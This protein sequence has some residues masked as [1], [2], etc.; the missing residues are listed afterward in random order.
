M[1]SPRKSFGASGSFVGLSGL[2]TSGP[3][4]VH[5]TIV[6]HAAE[7]ISFNIVRAGDILEFEIKFLNV[8]FP[9][10]DFWGSVLVEERKVPM[11]GAD[12]KGDIVKEIIQLVE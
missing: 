11:I 4:S 6:I 3:W 10:D 9:A 5:G 1:S 2:L 8:E 12:H 7:F